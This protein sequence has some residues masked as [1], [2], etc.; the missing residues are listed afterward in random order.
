MPSLTTSPLAPSKS[1]S[2]SNSRRQQLTP[3][4]GSPRPTPQQTALHYA[5]LT[6]VLLSLSTSATLA[7]AAESKSSPVRFDVAATVSAIPAPPASNSASANPASSAPASANPAAGQNA[8]LDNQHASTTGTTGTDGLRHWHVPLELSTLVVSPTTPPLDQMLIEI[9]LIDDPSVVHDYRPRTQTASHLVGDISV[10]KSHETTQHMGLHVNGHLPSIGKADAGGDL[11]GKQAEILK[12][13]RVAPVEIVAASGTTHRRRGAFFK[14]R[15]TPQQ[16]L[17][18]D[19]PLELTLQSPANWRGGLLELRVRGQR[20]QRQL[21]GMPPETITVADQRFIVAVFRHDDRPAQ[22]LAQNFGHTLDALRQIAR[23]E[24]EQIQRRAAPTLFHRVAHKLDLAPPKID[25]RWLFR[26]VFENA[27]PH[28]DPQL[29]RLPV[30][31]RVALLDYQDAKQAFLTHAH[32]AHETAPLELTAAANTP[33]PR[34]EDRT[35]Q[36]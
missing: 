4:N 32:A 29:R 20:I 28:V 13:Q 34:T 9:L 3:I 10:E 27:D 19:L 21:P 25:G 33:S 31:V 23:A 22:R 35:Q 17:E 5:R 30:N 2:Q 18:G 14:F 36:P 1:N 8:P 7:S 24:N 12:Y 16:V 6:L 15:R 11:G 26:A